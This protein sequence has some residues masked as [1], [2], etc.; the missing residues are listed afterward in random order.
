VSLG[1]TC[2]TLAKV[3]IPSNHSH[4]KFSY[5][6]LLLF[7]LFS[8]HHPH[9][10]LYCVCL[11]VCICFALF[12]SFAHACFIAGLWAAGYNIVAC[13]AVAE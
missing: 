3:I 1:V 8:F 7:P 5:C 10:H 11:W 4:V 13:R 12:P 6:Y 9:P 2:W